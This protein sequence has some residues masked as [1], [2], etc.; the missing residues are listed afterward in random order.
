MDQVGVVDFLVAAL[1]TIFYKEIR[2]EID[3]ERV[4]N[5]SI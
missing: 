5:E 2:V 1:G 3:Q 4:I